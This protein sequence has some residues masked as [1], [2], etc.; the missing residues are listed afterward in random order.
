MKPNRHETVQSR[1]DDSIGTSSTASPASG[2]SVRA[3]SSSGAV[4]D[5]VRSR[6]RRHKKSV[7]GSAGESRDEA[8]VFVL[9]KRSTSPTGMR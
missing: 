2:L 8:G 1:V 5:G 7:G 4:V 6:L 9:S 3:R